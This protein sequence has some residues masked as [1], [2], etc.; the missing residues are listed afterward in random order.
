MAKL[1]SNDPFEDR[2]SVVG[3]PEVTKD[4]SGHT[5][6]SVPKPIRLSVDVDPDLHYQ[7]RLLALQ[8]HVPAS[9]LAR[10][11]IARFVADEHIHS[12]GAT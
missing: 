10:E 11:A 7:L 6:P 4:R 8:R 9:S 3:L 1:L 5:S 2:S 12:S